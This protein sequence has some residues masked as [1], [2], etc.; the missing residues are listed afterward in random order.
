MWYLEEVYVFNWL[1]N[2]I[3]F[4]DKQAYYNYFSFNFPGAPPVPTEDLAKL[5]GR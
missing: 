4:V 3:S 2:Y 5:T 1:L